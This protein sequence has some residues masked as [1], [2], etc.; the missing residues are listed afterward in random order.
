MTVT[1]IDFLAAGAMQFLKP[2]SGAESI[3]RNRHE[4]PQCQ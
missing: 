4:T 3:Q 2:Y 1:E